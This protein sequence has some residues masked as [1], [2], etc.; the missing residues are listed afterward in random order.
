M[1]ALRMSDLV[2]HPDLAVSSAFGGGGI[3]F[4]V[5]AQITNTPGMLGQ[6]PQFLT[7]LKA[8][9]DDPSVHLV[10]ICFDEPAAQLCER[11][12]PP[13]LCVLDDWNTT[14]LSEYSYP[15]PNR[16]RNPTHDLAQHRG[17][18][19]WCWLSFLPMEAWRTIAGRL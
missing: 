1:A 10:V 9:P 2:A 16:K 3:R 18:R 19:A 15:N 12:H 17:R 13:E 14:R 5:I 11:H 8:Q 6:T 7:S 4:R